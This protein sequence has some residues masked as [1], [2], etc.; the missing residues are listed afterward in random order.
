MVSFTAVSDSINFAS[1]AYP[2][3][4]DNARIFHEV[5]TEEARV[6]Q[7]SAPAHGP[8]AAS[9]WAVISVM[10]PSTATGVPLLSKYKV[11]RWLIHRVSPPLVTT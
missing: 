10:I 8:W 7:K 11:V 3:L 5:G 9:F 6:G 2:I 1:T 4:N